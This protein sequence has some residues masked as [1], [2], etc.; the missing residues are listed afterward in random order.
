MQASTWAYFLS[1]IQ[2]QGWPVSMIQGGHRTIHAWE[3]EL[4][5]LPSRLLSMPRLQPMEHHLLPVSSYLESFRKNL[6]SLINGG[7]LASGSKNAVT[8]PVSTEN[9]HIIEELNVFSIRLV[10]LQS[11]IS[12]QHH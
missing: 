2:F 4:Y 10:T 11:L 12:S 3:L 7:N 8:F 6:L 1:F 5:S 9:I